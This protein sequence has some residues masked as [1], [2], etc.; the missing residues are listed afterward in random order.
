MLLIH[1]SI[2]PS[3]NSYP[4]SADELIEIFQIKEPIPN[5][6][7]K[8]CRAACRTHALIYYTSWETLLWAGH[9]FSL[10]LWMENQEEA[11]HGRVCA[12]LPV[13]G[14]MVLKWSVPLSGN[15]SVL[16]SLN[17]VVALDH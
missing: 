13:P 11:L 2:S 16:S 5:H 4:H 8:Q 3:P 1:D 7:A 6:T 9:L 14:F 12:A 15:L 17:E 10:G